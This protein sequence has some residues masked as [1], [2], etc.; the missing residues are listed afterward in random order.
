MHMKCMYKSFRYFVDYRELF[1]L[2][3]S[4]QG[5]L[6]QKSHVLDRTIYESYRFKR[7][8]LADKL[9]QYKND[10]VNGKSS[11]STISTANQVNGSI[12]NPNSSE[13]ISLTSNSGPA[14]SSVDNGTETVRI[15]Q[16]GDT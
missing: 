1:E 4:L 10:L 11:T 3:D 2:L 13:N 16:S 6:D 5:T 9:L 7:Q 8:Q 14:K 12:E 15:D